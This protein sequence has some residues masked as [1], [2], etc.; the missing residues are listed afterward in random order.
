MNR[1]PIK[2][3]ADIIKEGMNLNDTQIWIENQDYKIPET[4]GL[5]IIVQHISSNPYSAI[6]KYKENATEDGIEENVSLLT[7]EE[8]RI[9]IMS[10]NDD[11]R[12]RKEEVI[13]SLSSYNS[14]DN[15]G[16]YKF[17]ISQIGNF[18]NISN[19]EGAGVLTRYSLDISVLSRY[20]LTR[21]VP[22]YDTFSSEVKNNKWGKKW[23]VN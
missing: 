12:S 11:A 7:K 3:I 1:E 23:Q 19:V 14:Q 6:N 16:K 5:F 18:I 10:K 4:K 17:K 13:L 8:M 2:I 22:F 20:L 21:E 15:Q 9:N